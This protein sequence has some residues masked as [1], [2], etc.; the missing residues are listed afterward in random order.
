[1]NSSDSK[2]AKPYQIS[3]E[4]RPEYLYVY[5]TGERDSY[6]ISR[7]YWQ[8]VADQCGRASTKN[9]LIEE[10]IPEAISMGE[11]YQLASEI[12]SLGFFGIRIAFVD[13]YIEQQELN[14]FGEL[15]AVN[16]GLHGKIF[17]DVNEAEKWLLSE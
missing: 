7:Q 14:Q 3:F 5:V 9:V 11:M 1:M 8:E 10:D 2:P 12:P 15:V 16:R 17:N 13:R 4:Q 6:E